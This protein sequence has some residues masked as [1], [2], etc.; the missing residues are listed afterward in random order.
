LGIL[1]DAGKKWPFV[2]IR[3]WL[4]LIHNSAY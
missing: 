4:C 1:E 3:H 2:I